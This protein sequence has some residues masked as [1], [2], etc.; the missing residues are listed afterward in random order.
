MAYVV[1]TYIVMAFG[2]RKILVIVAYILMAYVVM[3]YIFMGFG[4]R[5]SVNHGGFME[6]NLSALATSNY[7][8][9]DLVDCATR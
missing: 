5:T 8:H 4:I 2:I 1:M 7:M 3:T 6:T 9:A